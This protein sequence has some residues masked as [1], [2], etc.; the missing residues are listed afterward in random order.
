M[1]QLSDLLEEKL[2]L[3]MSKLVGNSLAVFFFDVRI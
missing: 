3:V 2:Y 1:K